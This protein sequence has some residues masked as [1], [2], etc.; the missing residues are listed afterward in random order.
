MEACFLKKYR[1]PP[2]SVRFGSKYIL[3][4]NAPNFTFVAFTFAHTVLQ[5]TPKIKFSGYMKV[6]GPGGKVVYGQY[7]T[8]NPSPLF[9]A[10]G[11]FCIRIGTTLCYW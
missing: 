6:G 5:K 4:I 11:K 2:K 8:V 10:V 7:R 9:S 3:R 1:N